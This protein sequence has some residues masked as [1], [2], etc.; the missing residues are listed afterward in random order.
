MDIQCNAILKSFLCQNIQLNSTDSRQPLSA[1][2][3]T[4]VDPRAKSKPNSFQQVYL[5]FIQKYDKY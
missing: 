4:L 2:S 1:S 3:F 5:I